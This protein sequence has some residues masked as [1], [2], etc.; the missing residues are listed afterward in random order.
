MHNRREWVLKLACLVLGA[1]LAF[2]LTR[3]IL[4]GDPAKGLVIPAL[5]SLPPELE[6]QTA[7]ATNAPA[8]KTTNASAIQGS[9]KA[10]TNSST[11]AIQSNA[12]SL[13]DVKKSGVETQSVVK[14]SETNSFLTNKP[15]S[16]TN[17]FV[18]ATANKTQAGN[19][20]SNV[21][22]AS[23]SIIAPGN[24]PGPLAS[25]GQ[26]TNVTNNLAGTKTGT[27]A[28]SLNTSVKTNAALAGRMM[29]PGMPGGKP[30]ELPA[31][32]KER[33]DRIVQ[34][35]ILGQVMRPMPMALLGI[36]GPH[37]FLRSPEGQTGMIKEGETLGKLKLLRIGN[38]RVLV[39]EEGEKKELSIFA[40]LG[41]ETL[42]PA[43]ELSP[44]DKKPNEPT[45]KSP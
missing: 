23:N 41:S 34:G 26:G 9:A 29:M 1:L 33:V 3:F 28:N 25:A 31:D 35:E 10:G 21:S 13:T 2:Q 14:A 30:P 19:S 24:I 36:A 38:N 18:A 7:K 12:P 11:T 15:A 22:A 39:E 16:Q 45:V 42:M 17:S 4:V 32:I 20:E 43:K 5:P 8:A 6:T 44:K 27:N 40:G 37:A